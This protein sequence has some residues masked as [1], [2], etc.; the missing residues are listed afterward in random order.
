[1]AVPAPFTPAKLLVGVLLSPK[2]DWDE[3][4]E[5]L[6]TSLGPIDYV[7]EPL[8]FEYTDYY[9]AEMGTPLTRRFATIAALRDPS[10]LADAKLVTNRLEGSSPNRSYNLDPGLVTLHSV[11]LAT[12]KPHAHR[13]PI[14]SGIYAEVT[15]MYRSGTFVALPWTYPDYA[16]D[17]YQPILRTIR[18]N[19]HRQ[20]KRED[21]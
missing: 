21:T 13:I 6:V 11:L 2:A 16:G 4:R 17:A 3:V 1:M 10:T 5:K 18:N 8:S 14:H 7:S 15:L 19:Y 9:A 20:L 12:T